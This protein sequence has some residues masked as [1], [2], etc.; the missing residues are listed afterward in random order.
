M[1]R[2]LK[3]TKQNKAKRKGEPCLPFKSHQIHGMVNGK[4]VNALMSKWADMN[5]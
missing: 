3:N 2:G 5:N 4:D 1:S